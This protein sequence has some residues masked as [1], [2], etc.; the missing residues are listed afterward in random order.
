MPSSSPTRRIRSWRRCSTSCSGRR[1]RRPGGRTWC[2][3]SSRM[4][5]VCRPRPAPVPLLGEPGFSRFGFVGGDT[6]GGVSSG[7]PNGRRFGDDVVDIALTAV[8]SG[9]TYANIT[10]VGDNIAGNDIAFN[11]VFPYAATPH[12]GTRNRKDVLLDA[13]GLTST[14]TAWSIPVISPLSSR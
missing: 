10:V 13:S 3:C 5:C 8:A 9:P 2:R 6:T 12:A 7:W 11:R 14:R 4:S 1:L